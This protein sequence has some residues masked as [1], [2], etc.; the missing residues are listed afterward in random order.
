MGQGDVI[1]LL[2]KEK[3]WLSTKQITKKLGISTA[4]PC[5]NSLLRQKEVVRREIKTNTYREY[6]WR[7]K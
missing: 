2:E 6:Q 5:L 4:T 7:K 3:G 1:N